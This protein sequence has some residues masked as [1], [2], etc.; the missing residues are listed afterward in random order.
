MQVYFHSDGS[1]DLIGEYFSI[2]RLFP[3]IDGETIRPIRITFPS[4]D[5]IKYELETG[6]LE[7]RI[8]KEDPGISVACSAFGL[9]GIHDIEPIGGRLQYTEDPKQRE[10]D[11]IYTFAQGLGMEGPS[12]CYKIQDTVRESYGL[13]ALYEL[14]EILLF[15]VKDH[16]HYVNRYTVGK[17]QRIF[18]QREISVMCGFD[19]EG[20]AGNHLE[21][22]PV[23]IRESSGTS[24]N[25]VLRS[26][27]SA[28]AETMHA[29]QIQ[30]P[31]FHWCSWYYHYQNM[32]QSIL[33][34]YVKNF[35]EAAPGLRYIQLDAGY[36]PSLGDWLLPNHLFPEGLAKASMTI[37]KAGYLPG[38]WIGPFMAGDHSV[39]YRD[40]PDWILRDLRGNPVTRIRS[41]NEP[42]VWGNPDGNYYVLDTSHPKA[43]EYLRSVFRTLHQWGFR[44]FKTDFML[45]N[46]IDSSQVK[47]Y[48]PSRTSV[49]ILRDTLEMI[50][51]EIGE[52]S[53]LLGCIAP[54]LPF[55]GYADGMR[56]AGD[57]GAQWEGAYGP[58]NLLRELQ[59]D[60]YFQNLYWQND[61]D[62]VL[63]REFDIFLK[64]HEIESLA[65]LQAISG[66]VV[67][68]S[69]PIHCLTEERKKLFHF[70]RP[71]KVRRTAFFPF[72]GEDRVDICCT[73]C[74]DQGNLLFTMNPSEEERTF[75][76]DLTELFPEKKWHVFRRHRGS[77]ETEGSRLILSLKPHDSAL[78]FLTE[79][80]M[81]K[82]PDNL[83]NW[84]SNS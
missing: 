3:S 4:A 16:S 42:K 15:F 14:D 19:L 12:G 43:M 29:R 50:R 59:A 53:Y 1:W 21:L 22:P 81:E 37:L 34:E 11:G 69:D 68:T 78:F 23:F 46:M 56:I 73:H 39:L 75:V 5:T 57:V 8:Q 20:T 31:A 76:Y 25:Y 26:C 71:D 48:D 52:E 35:P 67:T 79:D 70:L 66:G 54:F 2:Y 27:A 58:V 51:E 24:L 40:H 74:L 36:C 77:Y 7:I 32:S 13:L 38:I 10:S 84:Q 41:Y 82:E 62:S 80:P 30:P 6:S 44:L 72:L 64:P 28:I 33:E 49:E 18:H 55:I 65:L 83:W 45:W 47:R 9:E 63:L 61:P 60:H 17:L